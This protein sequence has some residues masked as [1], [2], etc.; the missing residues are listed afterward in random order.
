MKSKGMLSRRPQA[1][2]TQPANTEIVVATGRN[3]ALKEIRIV[4]IMLLSPNAT[5]FRHHHVPAHC[6][7]AS[8]TRG[9]PFGR[10]VSRVGVCHDTGDDI[11]DCIGDGND[12][13][14]AQGI[15]CG[16]RGA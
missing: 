12:H 3:L 14:T 1:A 10:P 5:A 15:L 2:D 6:P 7:A 16:A 4:R 8:H 11:G 13:A 9:R